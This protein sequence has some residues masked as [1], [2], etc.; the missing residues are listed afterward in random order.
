MK[1]PSWAKATAIITIIFG[2]YALFSH[3]QSLFIPAIF[4]KINVQNNQDSVAIDTTY[5]YDY[6][7]DEISGDT[8]SVDTLQHVTTTSNGLSSDEAEKVKVMMSELGQ[9]TVK[10]GKIG[11][12]V[13]ILFTIAGIFMLYPKKIAPKLFFTA[14]IVSLIFRI[15]MLVI[16]LSSGNM[17]MI[18]ASIGSGIIVLTDITLL[19]IVI[20]NDKSFYYGRD[21]NEDFSEYST[22]V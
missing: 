11:I 1:I 2:A 9:W 10:F 14:I 17:M 18:A 7:I 21:P 19:L 20:F 4:E 5:N 15:S 22:E 8:L 13:A 16:F 6:K 12:F 3:V